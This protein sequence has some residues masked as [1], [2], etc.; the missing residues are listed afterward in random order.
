MLNYKWSIWF[1]CAKCDQWF[2]ERCL[3]PRP[4][5]MPIM[6]GDPFYLFL[7]SVCNQVRQWFLTFQAPWTPK[8]TTCGPLNHF[9]RGI[10]GYNMYVCDLRGPP[11]TGMSNSNYLAGRKCNKKWLKGR[12]IAQKVQSGPNFTKYND[13]KCLYTCFIIC[14]S[15]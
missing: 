4:M 12:K 1:Q 10:N 6:D 2:H 9:E 14:F 11:R 15:A 5:S 3:S 7:C 13:W 8:S